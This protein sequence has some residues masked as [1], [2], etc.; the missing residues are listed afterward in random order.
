MD[1]RRRIRLMFA[2]DVALGA[3]R[4]MD[5]SEASIHLGLGVR[6]NITDKFG[7]MFRT[8]LIAGLWEDTTV[9]E[10]ERAWDAD[11]STEV[12]GYD[13][14]LMPYFGPFEH[15]YFGPIANFRAMYPRKN[16][17]LLELDN[18]YY[19][20]NQYVRIKFPDQKAMTYGLGGGFL[21][22]TKEL[23]NITWHFYS[24]F[25]KRIPIYGQIGISFDLPFTR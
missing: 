10:S 14:E 3:L 24:S 12:V 11:N 2:S 22:G 13:M 23:I 5:I 25:T 8:N 19:E 18:I 15:F 9:S 16:E 1:Y 7:L 6:K 4:D 17:V 21:I 20:S